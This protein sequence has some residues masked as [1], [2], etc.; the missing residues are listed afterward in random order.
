MG[1]KQL[2]DDIKLFIGISKGYGA[3]DELITLAIYESKER[4]LAKLNEYSETEIT[5]IPDRLRFIVRDV[6]IKRFNRI[7]SEGAVEDSEE[8]KTFEWDSYLKEYVSTL[9]SAAIGKVYSG[10]GVARFI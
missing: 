3:Q 8:G 9:R 2:I 6:A 7:N 10:K 1:D 4:V 5:K